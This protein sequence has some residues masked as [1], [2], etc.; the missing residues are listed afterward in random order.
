MPQK[1]LRV[2][3]PIAIAWLVFVAA[4]HLGYRVDEYEAQLFVGSKR[5]QPRETLPLVS[6]LVF[7]ILF[8]LAK[9]AAHR[10]VAFLCLMSILATVL[11]A[12]LAIYSWIILPA[13]VGQPPWQPASA[14]N[15]T[16]M[17]VWTAALWAAVGVFLWK[18]RT[19][20]LTLALGLVAVE[21]VVIPFL[22]PLFGE[23]R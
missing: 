10:Q 3:I 1:F 19:A 5:L 4:K 2:L 14:T 16:A 9:V 20:A 17:I 11:V 8:A 12:S 13:D 7:A 22:Q 15:F 21:L 6:V 23:L 18:Q